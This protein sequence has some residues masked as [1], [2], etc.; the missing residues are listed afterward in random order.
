MPKYEEIANILRER[1]QDRTYLPD[2][3][4]PNQT[5]LV[6]EFNAS[7]TTIKKAI[8]ILTM[9]G[10]VFSQRGAGTKVLNH[11]FLDRNMSFLSDYRGLTHDFENSGHKL[12]SEALA[13]EVEF[14]DEKIQERLMLAPSQPVY[15]IIRLR[16][17]DN[18]PFILEHTYMPVDLVPGLTEYHIEHSIYQHVK[19][20]LGLKFAGAYRTISADRSSE[21][22]QK[23]LECSE[24]D[25]V[26]EIKQIVYLKDGRPVEYSRSRNRFDVRSYS[27]LDIQA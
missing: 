5:D 4:L 10:L 6:E 21:F 3:L 16:R 1:I 7:R 11:P 19:Q 27:Y 18:K 9:E 13:F 12:V 8:N 14:P 23:H 20:E 24:N 15:K 22:D 26:L 2:Q 25:P 17:L